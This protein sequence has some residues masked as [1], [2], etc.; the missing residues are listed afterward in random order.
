MN[1]ELEVTLFAQPEKSYCTMMP[2]NISKYGAFSAETKSWLI[3]LGRDGI[4]GVFLKCFHKA[5][6]NKATVYNLF[7]ITLEVQCSG[8]DCWK[9]YQVVCFCAIYFS[10]KILSRPDFIDYGLYVS[11]NFSQ[12]DQGALLPNLNPSD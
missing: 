1:T 6:T 4:S 9:D 12:L 11:I 5:S 8:F 2:F 10:L 7:N 3:D